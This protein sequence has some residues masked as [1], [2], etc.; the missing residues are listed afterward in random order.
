MSIKR[1]SGL[2]SRL[3]IAGVALVMFGCVSVLSASAMYA[4]SRGSPAYYFVR[5]LCWMLLGVACI[6]GMSRTGF[7]RRLPF[8][9][10]FLLLGSIALLA[11]AWDSRWIRCAGL[12]LQPAEFVKIAM[13]CYLA[14]YLAR[15]RSDLSS[16]KTV[17]K[18]VAF[19][20]VIMGLLQVQKDLGTFV[21]ICGA[22]GLMLFV[23]GLPVRFMAVMA[24]VFVGMLVGLVLLFPYRMER[25]TIYLNPSADANGKAYQSNESLKALGSGGLLGAGIGQSAQ[26]LRFLPEAHKDYVY[27]VIG[28]EM[29]LVGTGTILFLFAV[30][31]FTGFEIATLAEDQFRR[32][33]AVGLSGMLGIQFLLHASVVLRLVPPKGTTLPFCSV[34]GSSLLASM[35]ALGLLLEV[36]R[37]VCATSP[38]EMEDVPA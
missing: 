33:L 13:V 6:W 27:A 15:R 37:A 29:G 5:H 4:I 23:A 18:P 7:L 1:L 14:D 31:V 9:S 17:V 34:G 25:I 3:L 20:L 36:A 22:F 32:Y 11:V 19:L 30:I 35:L 21:I 10:P 8:L 2:Y 26:K 28:E 16:W 38:L 12:S 24:A